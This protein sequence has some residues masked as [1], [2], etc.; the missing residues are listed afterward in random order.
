MSCRDRAEQ[1]SA[2][3]DGELER[4][5]RTDLESHLATCAACSSD[6]REG[7]VLSRTIREGAAGPEPVAALRTKLASA[8]RVDPPVV[9]EGPVR[10]TWAKV[11]ATHALLAAAAAYLAWIAAIGW[12]RPSEE[13]RIGEA[14]VAAHVRSLL[15]DHL[16]DVASSD[17]HTVN[18]WFQGKVDFAVGAKDH[19]DRG[20]AL[21]GGRLD[22]VDGTVVASIVY[23]H[24][25]HEMNLFLWP[26]R[27]AGNEDVGKIAIRGYRVVHWKTNGVWRWLVSDAD[28]STIQEL[29][30]LLQSDG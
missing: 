24:A 1:L 16:T 14:V 26:S 17:R 15:A 8:L 23:R 18:P 4:A 22:Y 20:F 21:E 12:T 7:R 27:E 3:L 6:L 28:E 29:A 30:K 11:V 25:K 9:K 10:R 5:A 2:Y 19:A 13:Q